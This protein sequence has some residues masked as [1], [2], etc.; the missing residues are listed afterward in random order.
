MKL[1][2]CG[3][4]PPEKPSGIAPEQLHLQVFPFVVDLPARDGERGDPRGGRKMDG[5]ETVP[6]FCGLGLNGVEVGR[7]ATQR[8]PA[9]PKSFELRVV[10]VPAG[11]SSKDGPGQQ[12]FTPQR[13]EPPG[14]E[15]LGMQAPQAHECGL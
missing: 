7:D 12:T 13:H 6:P 15:I 1:R 14:V 8:R 9:P 5:G 2:A 3:G 11:S 4:A 10:P